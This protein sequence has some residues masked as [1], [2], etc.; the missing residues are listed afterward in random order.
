MP[1][2]TVESWRNL[3]FHTGDIGQKDEDGY[4]YFIDRKKTWFAAG[5]RTFRHMK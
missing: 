5:G 3:W 2:A 4:F 1:E